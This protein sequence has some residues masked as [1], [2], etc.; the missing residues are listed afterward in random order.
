MELLGTSHLA[1]SR[2]TT[3]YKRTTAVVFSST[4]AEHDAF[5]HAMRSALK[6][7]FWFHVVAPDAYADASGSI[8]LDAPC[9]TLDDLDRVRAN[10]VSPR[11]HTV[12]YVVS[13]GALMSSAERAPWSEIAFRPSGMILADWVASVCAKDLE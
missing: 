4:R 8:L 7:L 9:H 11:C 6:S 12:L 1:A 5:V 3:G 10:V 13:A 2:T